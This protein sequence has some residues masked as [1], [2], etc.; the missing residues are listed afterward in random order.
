MHIYHTGLSTAM[1]TAIASITFMN[2]GNP[3]DTYIWSAAIPTRRR[4][5]NY[6]RSLPRLFVSPPNVRS[7][8][9]TPVRSHK[10]LFKLFTDGF[11]E[12]HT[13]G[14]ST[15]QMPILLLVVNLFVRC[16]FFM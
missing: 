2:V 11:N 15:L 7:R 3:V 16:I 9:Y 13:L 14:L 8:K 4:R 5:R 10:A 1:T 12:I 6:S